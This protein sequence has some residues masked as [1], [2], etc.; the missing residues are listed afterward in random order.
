VDDRWLSPAD[1]AW[2]EKRIPVVCVD[3]IPIRFGAKRSLEVERVGLILRE[4]G[5]GTAGWCLIGGRVL[6]GESL[7]A[8]VRRQIKQALGNKVRLTLDSQ[9]NPLHVAQYSPSGKRPFYLD[10]RKHA[11]GLTYAVQ[12]HGVPATRG[13]AI[14]FE[15]FEVGHLPRAREF[16]FEQHKIVQICLE[17]LRN[18]SS[19]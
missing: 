19:T 18:R 7:A 4:T 12:I 14:R 10:P 16:G 8:T 13:E 11:I 2:V 6:L 9:I 15:W 17:H 3:V 5:T 1:W